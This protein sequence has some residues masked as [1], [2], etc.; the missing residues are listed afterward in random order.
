MYK[1]VFLISAIVTI[2]L[3]SF[4]SCTPEKEIK[5][6]ITVSE[7]LSL[8]SDIMDRDME[9]RIIVPK[10]NHEAER[11]PVLYVL[12]GMENNCDGWIEATQIDTLAQEYRMIIV[13]PDGDQ[14]GWY[15]DSP[16]LDSS[17][18]ESYITRELIPHIDQS[19]PTIADAKH[20]SISG[21]S[22]GGHGAMTLAFKHADKFAS[23]SSFYGGLRLTDLQGA[24]FMEALLGKYEENKELWEAN[25]AYHLAETMVGKTMP[26]Y[27]DCGVDDQ[28][29]VQTTHD[30]HARLE[31]LGI[32]HGW[33][34]NP[35]GHTAE[36]LQE[37]LKTHLDFHWKEIRE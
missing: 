2:G 20:R 35:G 6:E 3:I 9:Y 15:L 12:H 8:H 30:F 14:V 37:Q 28:F 16:L 31:E 1:P 27:F 11:F 21:A 36:Y 34:M 29:F 23:V 33:S 17:Q 19:Y 25:S 24:P 26:I 5:S 22:M 10:Q 32:E 18:I 13:F 4:A 7:R